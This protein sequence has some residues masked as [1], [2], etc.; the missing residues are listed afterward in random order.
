VPKR[1]TIEAD[2]RRVRSQGFYVA[3]R[4]K[5]EKEWKLLDGAGFRGNP[6]MLWTLLP[7]LPRG[8]TIPAVE[9]EVVEE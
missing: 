9:R 1:S 3:V 5:S 6:E 4:K 2:G 8:V 7:E